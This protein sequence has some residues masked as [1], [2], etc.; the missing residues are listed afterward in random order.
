MD[1][2][3]ASAPCLPFEQAVTAKRLYHDHAEF[4]RRGLKIRNK[5]G[6][7]VPLE[8]TPAQVRLT[9]VIDEE[10]ERNRPVRVC[11]LKPRQVHMSVGVAS[12]IFRRYCFLPGQNVCVYADF[13]R[14]A[15]NLWD[16]Y[17]Q[18]GDSYD[19]DAMLGLR[20]MR[21]MGGDRAQEH[22]LE[23]GGR[24]TY[25]SAEN[26]RSGRSYSYRALHLS[27]YAFWANAGR[28]M[29]GLMPTVPLEPGTLVVVES[30][31]NGRGGPFYDL[32]RRAMEATDD[33]TGVVWRFLFFGWH[34]HPEYSLPIADP[35]AFTQRMTDEEHALAQR[36]RLLPGQIAWRRTKINTDFEGDVLRFRQEYPASPEEA[37][38]SSGRP[39]FD[40]AVLQRHPVVEQP[41]SGDL[42]R[43][44]VGSQERLQFV[45]KV[46]SRGL[47][48][49]WRKPISG[50]RYVIGL[51]AAEGIDTNEGR[52]TPDPD[53][54]TAIALDVDTGELVARIR[55]RI[56]PTPFADAVTDLGSWYNAAFLVPEANG[57]GVAVIESLLRNGYPP[58]LMYQR[59]RDPNDRRQPL[60]QELGWRTTQSSKHDLINRLDRALRDLEVIVT[61]PV[62]MDE[63]YSFVYR[64]NGKLAAEG[65]G[66]D[67]LV[68]ALALAAVGLDAMPRDIMPARPSQ[69]SQM[70]PMSVVGRRATPERRNYLE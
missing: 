26:E 46:G 19:S 2:T 22:R 24:I 1:S 41:L 5:S 35:H 60:L 32:C 13:N 52:G 12:N 4:C 27:E 57:P 55:E 42:E 54:S 20:P 47:I 64:S 15:A 50:H 37:F 49:C 51:D 44:K 66:H 48:T 8:L 29:T 36:F 53:Y 63:L 67:D 18:F 21:I 11:V 10:F 16:Y 33:G 28:L 56:E 7:S 59:R 31:A 25:G 70:V 68:I 61:D 30:T 23:G 14:T 17:Q 45:P 38:L 6:V 58:R 3:P 40:H 39:R 34:E 69:R 9:S 43:V 62:T 65:N